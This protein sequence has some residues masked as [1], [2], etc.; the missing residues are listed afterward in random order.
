M[1][2]L[3]AYDRYFAWGSELRPWPGEIEYLRTMRVGPYYVAPA[4]PWVPPATAPA[5]NSRGKPENLPA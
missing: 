1:H 3:R 4:V 2:H 5:P